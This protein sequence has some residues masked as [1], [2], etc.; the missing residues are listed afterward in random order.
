M[1]HGTVS[2]QPELGVHRA[3]EDVCDVERSEWAFL[4]E[5]LEL[6]AIPGPPAGGIQADEERTHD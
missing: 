4:K 2:A 6:I 3:E 5:H 1:V